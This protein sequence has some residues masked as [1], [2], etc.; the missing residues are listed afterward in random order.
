MFYEKIRTK[1]LILIALIG[2]NCQPAFSEESYRIST[3]APGTSAYMIMSTFA[4]M[5]NN[6][7]DKYSI[8]VNATG[9]PTKHQL[10]SARGAGSQF[11]MSSPGM[12]SLM[13]NKKGMYSTISDA[14]EISKNLRSI[15]NFSM[16]I[17]HGVVYEESGIN[18]LLD[19]K[20]KRVFTGPPG[21]VAPI[22]VQR[23]IR[24]VTGYEPH[25][26][27]T[28]VKLGWDAAAQAF[29]DGNLDVYFN[30]TN[31]PSPVISQIAL[32][33]KI[34]LLGIP[35]DILDDEEIV[36]LKS[37]PGYSVKPIEKG[38]YGE[39]HMNERDVYSIGAMGGIATNKNISDQVAYEVTKLFWSNLSK[40]YDHSPW[41]RNIKLES[42][43]EDLDMPL[44]SGALK[45]Y[46]E[47]GLKIPQRLIV[48]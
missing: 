44:H 2:V 26:D 41:L 47:I 35:E 48:D 14:P 20:G 46:K 37:R 38:A 12:Y 13:K 45:Y 40:Q 3:L 23:L 18:S 21:G 9:A 27:Y 11:F 43:F 7:S 4:T 8:H 24:I 29:Q 16:G 6:N 17:Y 42:A 33:S 39:N 30:P 10:D 32:T 19:I 28:V 36:K 22:V 5:I 34:R 31:A 1:A 15:F 25:K